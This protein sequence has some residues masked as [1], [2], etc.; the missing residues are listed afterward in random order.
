MKLTNIFFQF[1]DM[2]IAA[3]FVVVAVVLL[4]LV[5]KRFPKW[6]HCT[7]WAMVAVRL[8]CPI[9]PESPVSIVAAE[10]AKEAAGELLDDYV[11]PSHT[12]WNISEEY[13][14]AVDAGLPVFNGEEGGSYVVTGERPQDK[15]S[16]FA[17]VLAPLWVIGIVLLLGY[18]WITYR[19]L[20][21]N[22][23]AS[24]CL[25]ENLYLC[26]YIDT[27][28]IL[29]ILKPK[30]YLPSNMDPNAASH[31]LA[32]ERAHIQRRDH[33]WKP[34]GYVLLCV[35]WFNPVIWIAYILLC[36]DIEMACDEKVIREM[37]TSDKKA[38]SEAL[39]S[40]SVS[41]RMIAA[42]PLA[43]GEV[44]VKQRIRAV[45]H[46]RKPGFWLL[47]L[48]VIICIGAAGMFLTD[49]V[50][51]NDISTAF[52]LEAGSAEK[53]GLL[54]DYGSVELSTQREMDAV[55]TLLD[56]I[57]LSEAPASAEAIQGTV[58]EY[59]WAYPLISFC[60][61]EEEKYLYFTCNFE[62][63]WMVSEEGKTKPY[64]VKNP[65]VIADFFKKNSA[66]IFG[67]EVTYAPFASSEE[68]WLWTKNLS[69]DAVENLRY[70]WQVKKGTTNGGPMSQ[71]RF[72]EM[73][74]ILHKIPK[75]A[76]SEGKIEGAY[77]TYTDLYCN[78]KGDETSAVWIEDGAN[79]MV[80]VVRCEKGTVQLILCPD[81]DAAKEGYYKIKDVKV[82]NIDDRAL[83]DYLLE[84][85]IHSPGV[86]VFMGSEYE[87]ERIPVTVEGEEVTIRAVIIKGWDYQV[88]YP[89]TEAESY[90]IRCRPGDAEE[91]W[92]YFS[93]W[94]DGFTLEEKDRYYQI[95]SNVY[96]EQ[97]YS[98]PSQVYQN[99]NLDT[100]GYQWSY[101]QLITPRG[102]YVVL[103]EDAESWS[104]RYW[105]A[106]DALNI[107]TDVIFPGT[108]VSIGTM[109]LEL[110][111]SW[112]YRTTEL[113]E[114][115]AAYGIYFRP[116]GMEGWLYLCC[117]N[118]AYSV[119]GHDMESAPVTYENGLTGIAHYFYGSD[120][121]G[122]IQ[123]TGAY[124][125]YI[126]FNEDANK[127]IPL[128]QTEID[129]ILTSLK[130][131]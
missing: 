120:V 121:W 111:Y 94:P 10:P 12:Y 27:P 85:D 33:W 109:S 123:F 4:R 129:E 38:Y 72:E 95:V 93:F 3:S 41:R 13:S 68:P 77:Y 53:F 14:K 31:V 92:L 88:I 124:E 5:L 118:A 80:A 104:E 16:V 39:L 101:R 83:K 36:R 24:I 73:L 62:R 48:T 105:D 15:P 46:Y 51:R 11:G 47:L 56:D 70:Y 17:D 122:N 57:L 66:V 9:A 54:S 65:K 91:G 96:G 79:Q 107:I 55:Q 58:D 131:G 106:I 2:S 18:A 97:R 59:G 7:L 103:L 32:H 82:W 44:G 76:F 71:V 89:R 113:S 117:V 19:K 52:E 114:K 119:V 81:Y 112:E 116:K 40:C 126:L 110:P 115:E 130:E 25:S 23:A 125:N 45:L 78:R 90:G 1:V 35:H 29:G 37:E 42:C 67:T 75:S 49:P 102:D 69:L 99:G 128:F 6:L 64:G 60:F 30:I 108:E 61:A 74:N 50:L 34:L 20:R 63:V 28:F 8:I 26:D 43:F 86:N 98:Y 127:W 22:V 21:R 87:W 84:M 100:R